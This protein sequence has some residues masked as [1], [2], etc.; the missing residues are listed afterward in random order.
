MPSAAG[1]KFELESIENGVLRL[2]I[3]EIKDDLPLDNRAFTVV[4][5]P[6]PAKV[7]FITPGND[8]LELVLAT[9]EATK[10][11]IIVTKPPKIWRRKPI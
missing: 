10:M 3:L 6:Q 1:V 2:E 7:L 8:A 11:A 9:D 4:N 5:M